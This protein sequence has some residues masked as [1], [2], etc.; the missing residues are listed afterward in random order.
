MHGSQRQVLLK[1]NGQRVRVGPDYDEK[2]RH[3][4]LMQEE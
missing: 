4:V 3:L 2:H 1:K